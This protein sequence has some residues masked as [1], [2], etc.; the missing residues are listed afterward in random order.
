MAGYADD[1]RAALDEDIAANSNDDEKFQQ[2]ANLLTDLAGIEVSIDD[3]K[4]LI[5]ELKAAQSMEAV[6]N[7]ESTE[8]TEQAV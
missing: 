1:M 7:T 8:P 2:V 5:D 4:G 3:V 6:E